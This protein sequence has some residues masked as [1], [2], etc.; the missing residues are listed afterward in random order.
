M[1]KGLA[2]LTLATLAVS[3]GGASA[4]PTQ[5]LPPV[6]DVA[7]SMVFC[8][9]RPDSERLGCYDQVAVALGGSPAAAR[10]VRHYAWRVDA[11][12]SGDG[13]VRQATISL[14][15][16]EVSASDDLFARPEATLVLRCESGFAT[17]W[18]SFPTAVAR[19]RVQTGVRYDGHAEAQTTWENSVSGA[20]IGIWRD[21]DGANG[22][23]RRIKDVRRLSLIFS[24]PE[25]RTVSTAFYVE[26]YSGVPD[27]VRAA[28]GLQ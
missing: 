3:L 23:V 17:V 26:R 19:E 1:R 7:R 9:A 20:A 14:G 5:R 13:S 16:S 21:R 18:V 8:A 2:S 4:Q 24:L 25:G 15:A 27:A 22:F 28:C 10:S 12:P 11:T 6:E